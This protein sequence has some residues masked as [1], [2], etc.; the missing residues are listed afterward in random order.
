M[1]GKVVVIGA[2]AAGMMAAGTAAE[3]NF[4]VRLFDK[5]ARP[6]R[7]VMITGKGRCNLTNDCELS[8]FLNNVPTNGRFLYSCLNQFGPQDTI[9]FFK[10]LGV[11]CKVERGKRVFPV[12]DRAVDIVDALHRFINKSGVKY[13]PGRVSSLIIDESVPG[14][15]T[16]KGIKLDSGETVLADAVIIATGGRSYPLTGSTGDGYALAESAGHHVIPQKPSLIPIVTQESWPAELQGLTLKNVV[17]TV[18]QIGTGKIIFEELG[19]MLFTHFGVSGPLI[20]SASS[21]IRDLKNSQYQILIDLKPALSREQLDARLQRDFMKNQNKDLINSLDELLPR[22]MI[23]VFVRLTGIDPK[24]KVNQLTREM[25]ETMVALL[26]ALPINVKD[27]RPIEEA[28]ITSGGVDI[29]Q[30]NP[31]TME[32]KLVNGLYF[33]GEVLDVDG[34]TGGF[35]LQIAFSTGYTAGV[36]VS[37]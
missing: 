14:N 31:K 15:K 37:T 1:T 30:I 25:R 7:K 13:R 36:A 22:K 10:K 9:S 21:R 28:I 18:R 6:G 4:E 27:F 34:Y 32:S 26:K 11:E 3:K 19:E 23:P 16:I 2:G 24:Q 17:V 20:L 8:E 5:N 12:S 29:R 33:A 35:N